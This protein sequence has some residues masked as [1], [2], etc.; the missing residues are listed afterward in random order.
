MAKTDFAGKIIA[1]LASSIGKSGNNY[2]DSTP[3]IANQAIARAC[4]E[5]IIANTK[6]SITYA[7]VM[8]NSSPDPITSDELT[9]L[10]EVAPPVGTDFNSW[11]NSLCSNISSGLLAQTG[12]KGVIVSP[13]GKVWTGV[14]TKPNLSG[15]TDEDAQKKAWETICESLLNWLNSSFLSG[16][17]QAT[18]GSSKGPATIIKVTVK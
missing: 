6:V 9:V 16:P 10:G 11:W 14:A 5:Y 4:T 18:H 2:N 7:G 17:Y 1:Q 15:C 12:Q 8:P 3:N 13:P